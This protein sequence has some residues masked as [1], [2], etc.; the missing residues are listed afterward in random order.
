MSALIVETKQANI[1]R[2]K[3]QFFSAYSPNKL[4]CRLASIALVHLLLL[5]LWR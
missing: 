4:L 1:V 5:L 3:Q 2:Q